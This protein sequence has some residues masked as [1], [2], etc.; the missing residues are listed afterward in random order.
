MSTTTAPIMAPAMR[1]VETSLLLLPEEDAAPD[2]L[3]DDPEVEEAE[4]LLFVPEPVSAVTDERLEL[5]R[6][7]WIMGGQGSP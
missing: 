1:P 4:A 2:D 6:L 5:F 7:I 3:G